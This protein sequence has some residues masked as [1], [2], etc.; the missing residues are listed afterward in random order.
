MS[1][2]GD[3]QPSRGLSEQWRH[4]NLCNPLISPRVQLR[5]APLA[6]SVPQG[7]SLEEAGGV[8]GARHKDRHQARREKT[9]AKTT[10]KAVEVKGVNPDLT[11]TTKKSLDAMSNAHRAKIER[12]EPMLSTIGAQ[13]VWASSPRTPSRGEGPQYLA[14]KAGSKD[15]RIV[16]FD[17]SKPTVKAKVLVKG[18]TSPKG[19]LEQFG[20]FRNKAKDERDS[21]RAAAKAKTQ[22]KAKAQPKA[23]SKSTTKRAPRKP[24]S[25]AS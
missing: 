23:S 1:S 7:S 21:A 2:G 8:K 13:H 12:W 19:L 4:R 10:T 15:Y 14:I 11:T 17:S 18:I 6:P 20:E 5:L 24:A 16:S 25:K 3:G 9:M 22:S